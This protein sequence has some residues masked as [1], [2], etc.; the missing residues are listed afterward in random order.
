MLSLWTELSIYTK[1]NNF[2]GL[3]QEE[4]NVEEF[5]EMHGLTSYSESMPEWRIFSLFLLVI[6]NL[7]RMQKSIAYARLNGAINIYNSGR[8]GVDVMTST[9]VM[10]HLEQHQEIG[11][12]IFCV[13]FVNITVVINTFWTKSR[14]EEAMPTPLLPW[15]I[16]VVSMA[17]GDLQTEVNK[18]PGRL[19]PEKYSRT[20]LVEI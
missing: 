8:N 1:N 9:E 6:C 14:Y 17:A 19:M 12:N 18:L 4:I 3:V 5:V 10:I 11:G 2:A 7:R 15:I 20:S 16:F 13:F